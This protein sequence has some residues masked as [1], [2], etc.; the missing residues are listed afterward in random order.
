MSK[1]GNHFYQHDLAQIH[2]SGYAEISIHAA[3][4]ILDLLKDKNLEGGKLI[5]LGCGSGKLLQLVS[6]KGYDTYGIDQSEALLDIA[7][8][9]SP[10]AELQKG[11]I[12]L[13]DFPQAIAISAIGEVLNYNFDGLNTDE[14]LA[15]LFEKCY[16]RLT[17]HGCL[18]FDF[19]EPNMLDG[20][21]YAIRIIEDESWD[22][23]V[24]YREDR[25]NHNFQRQIRTFKKVDKGLY[26]K[27]TEIHKVRLFP[28][29]KVIL[30]LQRA[31]FKVD[32]LKNYGEYALRK[33]QWAVVATK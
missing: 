13:S 16:K 3:N 2:D 5:D 9:H 20:E 6:S 7:R 8:K 4:V 1:P 29:E 11:N 21:S 22:M 19:L 28:K 18:I 24:E 12:W 23:V 32:L 26:R 17:E 30:L 10:G 27:T 25:E 31:G 14:N 15:R 33:N